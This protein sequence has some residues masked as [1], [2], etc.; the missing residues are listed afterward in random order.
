MLLLCLCLLA[1]TAAALRVAVLGGSGIVGSR[2]CRALATSSPS[3]EVV[4]VSRSGTVPEW[5]K[6]DDWTKQVSWVENELTRGSRQKLQEAIGAPD[7]VVSCVGA[8]GFD[9]QGLLLGN[10]V[11]NV[12]AA[13]AAKLAGAQRMAYVSVGSEVAA[14]ENWLPGFFGAYFEGKRTAEEAVAAWLF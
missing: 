8:I 3:V 1:P 6:G 7:A 4:S 9:R 10:G 13:K 12:E 5:C 14:S 2:V 11:A